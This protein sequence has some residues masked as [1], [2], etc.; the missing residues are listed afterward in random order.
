MVTCVKMSR[1]VKM[2]KIVNIVSKHE[3][4]RDMWYFISHW[5][6]EKKTIVLTDHM[7]NKRIIHIQNVLQTSNNSTEN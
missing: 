7:T 3:S 1:D 4:K 2:L 5:P 6:N